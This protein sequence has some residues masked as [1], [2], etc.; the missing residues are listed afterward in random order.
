LVLHPKWGDL[1]SNCVRKGN[2]VP[3]VGC[4]SV[5]GPFF[6][7]CCLPKV[8]HDFKMNFS[9]YN[10]ISTIAKGIWYGAATLVGGFIPLSYQLGKE[11]DHNRKQEIRISNENAVSWHRELVR[12]HREA[13]ADCLRK[14]YDYKAKHKDQYQNEFV[15]KKFE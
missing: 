7:V 6:C 12:L 5:K 14:I 10:F 1:R 15:K 3:Q 13:Y 11:E 8:V 4:F 2:W 9:F